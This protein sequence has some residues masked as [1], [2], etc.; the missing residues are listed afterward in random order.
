MYTIFWLFII[1]LVAYRY[2]YKSV[3]LLAI[4]LIA[5]K[6][7]D[8]NQI[9]SYNRDNV[10]SLE[11]FC[12]SDKEQTLIRGKSSNSIPVFQNARV[13]SD[14]ILPFDANDLFTSV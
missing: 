11:G 4:L 1:A 7:Y 5:Y 6:I 8:L 13:Q 12:L 14:N 3:M 2:N 9:Q 10:G